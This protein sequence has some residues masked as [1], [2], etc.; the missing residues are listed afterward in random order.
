MQTV[1]I[2]TQNISNIPAQES[3]ILN[4]M[5]CNDTC[6]VTY[7]G[8]IIIEGLQLLHRTVTVKSE[9]ITVGKLSDTTDSEL[10]LCAREIYFPRLSYPD[11]EVTLL[12]LDGAK[13]NYNLK[14]LFGTYFYFDEATNTYLRKDFIK[15]ET[16][17]QYVKH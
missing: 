15:K 14:D 6:T 2:N 7:N 9:K 1:D 12:G 4:G 17:K 3:I 16:P 11:L 5:A 8:E 10:E 13:E